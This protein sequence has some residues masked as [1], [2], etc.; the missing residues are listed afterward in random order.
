MVAQRLKAFFR[1]VFFEKESQSTIFA[2]LLIA[3]IVSRIIA[4]F[5]LP[6]SPSSFGPDEGTYASLADWVARGLPVL[7]FP[8]YGAGLYNS[9]KTFILPSAGFV[10]LGID[11]LFSTRIVSAIFGVLSI[12]IVYS[13]LNL[14]LNSKSKLI[15]VFTIVYSF[16]PSNFLWSILGLRESTVQFWFLLCVFLFSRLI[17]VNTKMVEGLV[18]SFM[19]MLVLALMYG[20]RPETALIL[21]VAL[22]LSGI[23]T[24][25][26]AK[27]RLILLPILMG[28][29]LGILY[30]TTPSNID[31]TKSPEQVLTL[32]QNTFESKL[33]QAGNF[34]YKSNVNRLDAVSALPEQTCSS[35]R[36]L[37]ER[38]FCNIKELPFRIFSVLFRP[39]PLLEGG[40]LSA[41]IAAFE[42]LGWLLLFMASLRALLSAGFR[43]FWDSYWLLFLSFTG[44][45]SVGMALFEGNLGTAFRHKSVLL[46]VLIFVIAH[47]KSIDRVATRQ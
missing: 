27:K 20:T 29:V 34:E 5:L 30:V 6:S 11:P 47:R 35:S 2:Y 8:L 25:F 22:I 7:N 26:K 31:S 4:I 41:R 24:T 15:L 17:R 18:V 13:L 3:A 40:S 39:F 38:L 32:S 19:L 9:S 37:T 42:N 36:A 14:T 43:S 45:Y 28:T 46:P 10:S 44:M 33:K 12:L 1:R 16:W 23:I 21:S